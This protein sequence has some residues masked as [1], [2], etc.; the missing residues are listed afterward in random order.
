[1]INQIDNFGNLNFSRT[2]KYEI[3]IDLIILNFYYKLNFTNRFKLKSQSIVEDDV[4]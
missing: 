2:H 1:M 3:N 4:K